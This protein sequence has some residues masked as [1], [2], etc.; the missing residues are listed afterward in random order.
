[1]PTSKMLGETNGYMI[2]GNGDRYCKICSYVIQNGELAVVADPDS[3]LY[4]CECFDKY[5]EKEIGPI[6]DD[7]FRFKK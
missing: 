5:Y 7:H 3:T 6:P 4:C 2:Y 1:M